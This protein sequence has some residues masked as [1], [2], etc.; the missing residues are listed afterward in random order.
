MMRRLAM[1]GCAALFLVACGSDDDDTGGG[2]GGGG[3]GGSGGSS[4][5]GGS[6]ATGGSGT[7]G[8]SGSSTGGS[9][10][11][12]TGGNAGAGATGPN[13]DVSDPQLYEFELDPHELDPTTADSLE[14]QFA[15]LDT[16]ATPLGK[17]VI[18]LSGANNSPQDWRDHGRELA[19]FGFHVVGPHYNNRWS[20]NGTCDGQP[21]SCGIDTRWEALVGEDTS[22]AIEI[23]RADS[24]EGRVVTM[25]KFLVTEHPGGDWGYYLGPGDELRYDRMIIGGISHGAAST[26]LYAIRRAFTRAVMHSGGPQGD[27]NEAKSTPLSEW[28]GFVHTEDPAYDAISGAFENYGLLGTLTSIDRA[29]PPYGN[30]HRLESSETS[31]YPHGSTCAHSSSPKDGS[32]E[33]VFEPAWKHLYGVAP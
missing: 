33:Y 10:G 18:F 1:L 9:S 29:T 7:G 27:K 2:T 16:R 8:S 3:T 22:S 6:G 25:L 4:A 24:A 32:D 26:G 23:P 20:T 11:S 15:H 14:N 21:S 30:S 5:S 12:S 31:S 28:Y 13:V 19:S 17:L